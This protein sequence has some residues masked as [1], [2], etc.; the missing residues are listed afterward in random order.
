MLR[1]LG[2]RLLAALPTFIGVTIIVFL[3]LHLTPGDPARHVAGL[4]A[5]VEDLEIVRRQ[6][7]L[8]LPLPVQYWNFISG[9]FTGDMGAS[10]MM[11]VPVSRLIAEVLPRTM[12]LVFAAIILAS[13]IGISVGVVAAKWHDSFI[14]RMTMAGAI[15]GISIPN[16]WLGQMLILFVAVELGWLPVSGV[17]E[18]LWSFDGARYLVLPAITA[19]VPSAAYIARLT[20]SNMQDV[21]RQDYVRTARAKGM[22]ESVVLVKHALRNTLIPTVTLI[23]MQFGSLLG[24]AIIVE[25]V[26][27]WP[28]L[29]RLI[30]NATFAKDYPVVQGGVVVI[31]IVFIVVNILVDLT[32]K[33]IDPKVSLD[34]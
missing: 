12:T 34:K 5:T 10:F 8:D 20:R 31:A 17:P 9:L 3:I 13:I 2:R 15:L 19:A 27:A 22:S 16:F 26:F 6:L 23:G 21:M 25:T 28:G 11:K 29:G 14:D 1:F 32:Y 30:I 33:I 4:E 18:N 24:E 7:G